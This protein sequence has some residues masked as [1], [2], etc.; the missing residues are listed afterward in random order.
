M[1]TE[2]AVRSVPA[3]DVH[4]TMRRTLV[5]IP[6][7]HGHI[8]ADMQRAGWPH[9]A[10]CLQAHVHGVSGMTLSRSPRLEGLTPGPCIHAFRS[11]PKQHIRR[12]NSGV[13]SWLPLQVAGTQQRPTWGPHERTCCPACS[14]A[15][16]RSATIP[17]I[18]KEASDDSHIVAVHTMNGHREAPT[19]ALHALCMAA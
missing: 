5:A 1:Q 12:P 17:Y 18:W 19:Q 16:I 13:V 11:R 3:S 15:G 6:A 8:Q 14:R 4:M 9:Q 7:N 10:C 2:N